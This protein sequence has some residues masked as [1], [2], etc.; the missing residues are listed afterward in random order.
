[1]DWRAVNKFIF[2]INLFVSRNMKILISLLIVFAVDAQAQSDRE[3]IDRNEF[4]LIRAGADTKSSIKASSIKSLS[5]A[6]ALFG[7]YDY[8]EEGT[9]DNSMIGISTTFVR[10]D[11]G[12][13]LTIPHPGQGS[14]VAFRVTSDKYVLVLRNGKEIKVGMKASDLESI[15]PKSFAKRRETDY[16]SSDE[17]YVVSVYFYTKL[18][19]EI[20]WEEDSQLLLVFNKNGVLKNFRSYE[21][22]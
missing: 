10:Y 6:R 22:M 12:L 21:P 9:A 7:P 8:T 2:V 17:M 3:Y 1:V 19:N 15:Y 16:P 4:Y 5:S 13:M 14:H 11:D 18:E 20:I